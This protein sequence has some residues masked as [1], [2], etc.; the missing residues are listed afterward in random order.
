MAKVGRNDPCPC[1]SGK[2]YKNC[3]MIKDRAQHIRETVWIEDE[4]ATV[5]RLLAFARRAAF[6]PQIVV[7]S[8]LFWNGNYGLDALN[9]L[10]PEDISRFLDWYVF[11]YRL[12]T[13]GR[14]P[15]ELFL[16]ELGATLSPVE[17]E[18]VRIW[19]STHLS[20]Y[21]VTAVS[22][23][24]S[25]QVADVLLGGEQSLWAGGLSK[26]GRK[27]DLILGRVLPT[28][29]IAHLSWA[30]TLLPSAIEVGCKA[31]MDQA[32]AQIR[33]TRVDTSY[34]EFLSTSGYLFNHYLLRYAAENVANQSA[35][36]YY[37]VQAVLQILERVTQQLRERAAKELEQ[38]RRAAEQQA[39]Q[40]QAPEA[41][42]IKRT[43]GGILLP[44]HVDY[45][46]GRK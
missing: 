21:R 31:F 4:Q 19:Q 42:D 9:A 17:R 29:G 34:T 41:Q 38:R 14:R 12:E 24:A 32:Y 36:P 25:I 40:Q 2:K 46:R 30:A 45:K 15:V 10:R 39:Q 23:S 3:C 13:N 1:G 28:S 22:E 8:N 18:N 27:G 11:D 44:G 20:L 5:D 6:T 16:T 35:G 26:L 37:D 33:E 7:A 43:Q